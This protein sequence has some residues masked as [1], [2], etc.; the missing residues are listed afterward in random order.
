L[1]DSS[2]RIFR[3]PSVYSSSI[4]WICNASMVS[5]TFAPNSEKST[6]NESVTLI[7]V[8]LY[9]CT[10]ACAGLRSRLKAG[11]AGNDRPVGVCV[12]GLCDER[13]NFL[14][15]D[16][17]P[18][19]LA[20]H[21][22]QIPIESLPETNR[23]VELPAVDLLV[24]S[25]VRAFISGSMYC[26]YEAFEVLPCFR[27]RHKCALSAFLD[28]R[29]WRGQPRRP[30]LLFVG[31]DIRK[32]HC[33]RISY[34]RTTCGKGFW[35]ARTGYFF[36]LG[37]APQRYIGRALLADFEPQRNYPIARPHLIS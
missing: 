21:D 15:W 11:R 10:T 27:S 14:D 13:F 35:A 3:S 32:S 30:N 4:E 9:L 28:E 22:G 12:R 17:R 7:R 2:G 18:L 23:D 24:P 20:F 34:L 6:S 19:V 25:D 26:R 29:T 33:C 16:R 8:M 1:L 36:F 31:S 5:T 37:N